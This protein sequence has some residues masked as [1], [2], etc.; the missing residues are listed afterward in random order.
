MLVFRHVA[1]ATAIAIGIVCFLLSAS[2]FLFSVLVRYD[3]KRLGKLQL[4]SVT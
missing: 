2:C 3:W 1:T 4:I